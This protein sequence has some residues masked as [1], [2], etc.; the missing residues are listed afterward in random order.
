MIDFH[1]FLKRHNCLSWFNHTT[2]FRDL[3]GCSSWL[4][5]IYWIVREKLSSVWVI[6]LFVRVHCIIFL[7]CFWEI[8]F[9]LS[10][11]ISLFGFFVLSLSISLITSVTFE[12]YYWLNLFESWSFINNSYW[13]IFQTN[14]HIQKPARITI[15]QSDFR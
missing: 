5:N 12:L 4:S 11:L 3:I 15:N 7:D 10:D 6:Y 8:L 2:S 14:S 13:L 9:P 1:S